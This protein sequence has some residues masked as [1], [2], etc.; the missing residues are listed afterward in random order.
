MQNTTPGTTSSTEACD[1]ENSTAN[2]RSY[3]LELGK[4]ADG[5]AFFAV[6]TP[7]LSFDEVPM[8]ITMPRSEWEK[9]GRPVSI[10]VQL[11]A[12]TASDTPEESDS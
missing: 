12:K 3:S 8:H 9:I 1:A 11:R 7:R 5:K 10:D 2:S 6:P 4:L